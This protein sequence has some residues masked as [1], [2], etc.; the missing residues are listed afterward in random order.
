MVYYKLDNVKLD[1]S[2]IE[3]INT[4]RIIILNGIQKTV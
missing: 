4:I 3:I 1:L 2:E